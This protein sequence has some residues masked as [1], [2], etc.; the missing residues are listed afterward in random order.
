MTQIEMITLDPKLLAKI[1]REYKLPE[2]IA[3]RIAYGDGEEWDFADNIGIKDVKTNK[4]FG[5]RG[6]G[7]RF[8]PHEVGLHLVQET[9]RHNSKDLG[10]F[11][12]NIA[13]YDEGKRMR[14]TLT[15]TDVE[16]KIAKNDVVNPTIEYFNS[17]DGAWAEKLMFGAYRLICSNGLVVGEKFFSERLIH[18]GGRPEEF[19]FNLGESMVN[20]ANQIDVWRVWRNITATPEQIEALFVPF[21]NRHRDEFAAKEHSRVMNL[22]EVFNAATE[23]TTHQVNSVQH[24]VYLENHIRRITE[25]WPEALPVK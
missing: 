1:R 2:A 25:T 3:T 6:G 19:I 14:A 24:R 9:A 21:T 18:V 15:F 17:Y 20:F 7:Y 22:W 13:L 16:Y 12:T 4:L 23:I 11:D 5:I 8:V 10:D